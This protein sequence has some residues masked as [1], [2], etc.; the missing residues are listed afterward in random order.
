MDYFNFLDRNGGFFY[1]RW[2]DAP[3]HS[4][5]ASLMLKKDEIH[6]FNDIAYFHVPFTHCPTG[7]DLRMKLKCHCKPEENFDWKGYSC[8]SG[9]RRKARLTC[10]VFPATTTSTTWK[11]RKGMKRSRTSP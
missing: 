4:V 3:V 7:E 1:E 9:R 11:S 5:A 10:Q 8:E 2:G 6:F